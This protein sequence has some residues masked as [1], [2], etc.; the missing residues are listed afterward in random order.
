[1]NVPAKIKSATIASRFN[2]EQ[3]QLI[4]DTICKGATDNE[5]KLF[6]YQCE[7]T[8]LDPLS[9]QIYAIK[10][11]DAQQRREAMGI[12]VSIDGFRLIAERSGK[13]SGQEGPFW[14]GKDGVWQDVWVE[15]YAPTAARIGVLRSDFSVPCWGVARLGSYMQTNKEGKPTK[16]WTVMPDVMLAKC[17]EALALRKAFPQELSGLYTSDEMEQAQTIDEKP[18]PVALKPANGTRI[19][20]QTGEITET[21]APEASRIAPGA[22]DAAPPEDTPEDGA[23][24][25][26]EDMARAEARK[27]AAPMRTFWFNCTPKEQAAVNRI[28]PEIDRLVTEAEEAA[29][30]GGN[31]G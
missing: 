30:E 18:A 20:A 4:K 31:N 27:G 11:W 8:G 22:V 17:A 19:D 29:A 5:L 1:M 3:L 23:A 9:R 12:Q 6:L 10:R 26:I 2:D 21:A 15:T 16:T 13:Y 24:Q 14:C 7:R 25:S 28:R